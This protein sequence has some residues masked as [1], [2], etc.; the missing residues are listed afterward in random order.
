MR[1]CRHHHP[2][3]QGQAPPCLSLRGVFALLGGWLGWKGR[4]GSGRQHVPLQCLPN[5]RHRECT[6]PSCPVLSCCAGVCCVATLTASFE[7][8]VGYQVHQCGA[9]TWLVYPGTT[10]AGHRALKIDWF[11]HCYLEEESFT[12]DSTKTTDFLQLLTK[13]RKVS[14]KDRQ[15]DTNTHTHENPDAKSTSSAAVIN[16]F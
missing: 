4:R 13:L 10:Y 3:P 7:W 1:D 9:T 12:W 5:H 2:L 16:R 14:R 15:T 8:P 6:Y 11:I